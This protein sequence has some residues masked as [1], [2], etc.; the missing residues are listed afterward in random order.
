MSIREEQVRKILLEK[1]LDFA[2][3]ATILGMMIPSVEAYTNGLGEVMRCMKQ[4]VLHFNA[5]GLTILP[6]DDLRGQ[7]QEKHLLFIP[8][9]RIQEMRLRLEGR[10]F[11]LSIVTKDGAIEYRISKKVWGAPWHKENLAHILLRATSV[12]RGE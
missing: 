9:A 3:R 12:R 2:Q 5:A 10:K 11:R 7:M 8:N 4:N 6:I 1:Q